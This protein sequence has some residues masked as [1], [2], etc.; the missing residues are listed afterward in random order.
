MKL[1]RFFPYRKLSEG[2]LIKGASHEEGGVPVLV[3]GVEVIEAEG[4]EV[5]INKKAVEKKGVKTRRGTNKKILNDINTETGGRAIM[6]NGGK[7][8]NQYKGKTYCKVWDEWT[9]KQRRHFLKDHNV[10]YSSECIK[11]TCKELHEHNELSILTALKLHVKEGQYR[12][13]GRVKETKAQKKKV[14]KVM[15]EFKNKKLKSHG[16]TVKKR[17]Q[18]KAIAMSEAGLSKNKKHGTQRRKS[19]KRA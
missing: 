1:L 16:K 6:R 11:Y 14:S 5:I 2:G 17:K 19:K 13:G 3:D 7:I 9:P 18:A 8:K 4:D 10:E 12:K 15:R